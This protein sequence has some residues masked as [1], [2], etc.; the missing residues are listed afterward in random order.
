M[1]CDTD[2]P[3]F[4][5]LDITFHDWADRPASR[6][7]SSRPVRLL[8][9]QHPQN[10]SK[11]SI[12]PSICIHS[13]KAYTF[14]VPRSS[15]VAHYTRIHLKSALLIGQAVNSIPLLH[16]AQILTRSN[17]YSNSFRAVTHSAFSH[18]RSRTR[19]A[20]RLASR[21]VGRS[22]GSPF[23]TCESISWWDR[24]GRG[25]TWHAACKRKW[26]GSSWMLMSGQGKGRE[27]VVQLMNCKSRRVEPDTS[28]NWHSWRPNRIRRGLVDLKF[29]GWPTRLKIGASYKRGVL[30]LSSCCWAQN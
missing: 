3:G 10:A 25:M 19:P 9:N 14:S 26:H 12:H 17:R 23:P 16:V 5:C 8:L 30:L 6:S 7:R 2:G 20:A 29:L 15:A 24:S 27:S 11:S 4:A 21:S 18:L 13:L 28:L 22:V 1:K